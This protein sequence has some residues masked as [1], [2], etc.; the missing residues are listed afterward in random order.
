MKA[1]MD[2]G[3][4]RRFGV[5]PRHPKGPFGRALVVP[6]IAWLA[7]VAAFTMVAV[8]GL[9]PSDHFVFLVARVVAYVTA[10]T[11]GA[12]LLLA[13]AVF[14]LVCGFVLRWLEGARPAPRA[15]AA[16]VGAAVGAAVWVWVACIW[17]GVL[18]AAIWTPAPLSLEDVLQAAPATTRFEDEL[19]FAWITGSRFPALACFLAWCVWRL[20]R[21][22]SWRDACVAVACAVSAVA[23]VAAALTAIAGPAPQL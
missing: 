13:V 1:A 22:A 11:M 17:L 20:A 19:A 7:G 5:E 2:I 9:L 14:G 12:F 6:V 16:R 3:L 21:I 18:L 4:R 10:A 8:E 23:A 15:T